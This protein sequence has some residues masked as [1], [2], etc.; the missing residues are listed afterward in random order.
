MDYVLRYEAAFNKFMFELL[1]K[2]DVI[3]FGDFQMAFTDYDLHN[4]E[5]NVGK[6]GCLDWQRQPLAE[7]LEGGFQ[8][9]YRHL[10]PT[11]KK[12]TYWARFYNSRAR[13]LGW[14]MDYTLASSKKMKV[15]EAEIHDKVEGSD[16]CPVST[17]I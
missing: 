14:R 15:V 6:P 1:N 11:D 13:G 7:L 10:H 8:D 12:Y 5:A 2:K 16:H 9:T 3:I 4:P 17:V